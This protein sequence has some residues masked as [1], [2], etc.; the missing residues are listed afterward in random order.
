MQSSRMWPRVALVGSDVSEKYIAS[1]IRVRRM[2]EIGTL[3][4]TSN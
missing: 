4:V 1:I 3:V 2:S